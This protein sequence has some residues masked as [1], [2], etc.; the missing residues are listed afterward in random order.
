MLKQFVPSSDL[1]AIEKDLDQLRRVPRRGAIRRSRTCT[2]SSADPRTL[3]RQSQDVE[4]T[5]FYQQG[6]AAQGNL[7]MLAARRAQ[8]R[9][10]GP[11]TF[12]IEGLSRRDGSQVSDEG[13]VPGGHAHHAERRPRGR[14]TR[15]IR[16]RQPGARAPWVS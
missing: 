8:N 13:G 15:P 7:R 3:L 11:E 14:P 6:P 9:E 12:S 4:A 16:R 5:K 1:T 10:I 2:T